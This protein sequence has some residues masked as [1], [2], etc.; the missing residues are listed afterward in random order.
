MALA[1]YSLRLCKSNCLNKNGLFSRDS[2]KGVP[3]LVTGTANEPIIKADV[4]GL[5][6]RRKKAFLDR[7]GKEQ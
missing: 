2:V 6:D 5:F 1:A 4:Q 7:F 3:I